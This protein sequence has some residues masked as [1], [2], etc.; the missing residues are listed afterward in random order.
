MSKDYMAAKDPEV[1]SLMWCPPGRLIEIERQNDEQEWD[2]IFSSPSHARDFAK[3]CL[4]A[5]HDL[6]KERTSHTT[7]T[8]DSFIFDLERGD[9]VTFN[10]AQEAIYRGAEIDVVEPVGGATVLLCRMNNGKLETS[11]WGEWE[12]SEHSTFSGLVRSIRDDDERF[13]YFILKPPSPPS[14]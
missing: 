14:D 9:E 12:Q 6:E 3:A 10:I 5:A 13:Q 11:S 8:K 1:R 7:S 2:L 4:Q